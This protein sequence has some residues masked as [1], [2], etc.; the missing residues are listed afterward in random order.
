MTVST[1]RVLDPTTLT[2]LAEGFAGRIITP[3][4]DGYD[5]A[6]RV[7]NASIDKRPA[8]IV[9]PTGV[10]DVMA[11]LRF[12]REHDL[13]VAVRG[14]GHS[15]A[16]H[17]TCDGG[18]VIDLGA[19]KGIR[20]D[21]RGRRARV[22]PGV[23]WSE[24]DR[25][26]QTFGLATTGG[27][28]GSTGVAGFTLG[29]GLGWLQRRYG[30]ACDNLVSADVVLA[31][32]SMVRASADEDPD[33]LWALRGGGGNF[34]IVTSF[35]LELH[36]VGPQVLGG[37]LLFPAER[38]PD[39]IAAYRDLRDDTPDELMLGLVLRLAPPA[40]FLPE[41]V[42]GRPVVGI[43]A[44]HC[45]A[46]ED[47]ER[48]I[49]PIRSV[50][51]PIVDLVEPR[52]YVQMQTM[53]D[54]S[55]GPGFRNYWKAEFLS[56]LPDAATDVLLEHLHSITSPLSDFKFA[57]LGGAV[58][59]ATEEATA[60]GHRDAFTILNVNARWTDPGEDE[61]HVA[62]TRS[63]WRAMQPFS[64]GGTYTNFTSED[65][66]DR[67]VGSFGP[68]KYARLAELKRRYDPTNLFRLNQNIVPAGGPTTD[69]GA[70]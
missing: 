33:L 47:G 2:R 68:S 52:P 34:G 4:D 14:G 10:A 53:Q 24:L 60:F 6:R 58:G 64:A 16:G 59:R 41:E 40:P 31:D 11:A 19:M 13:V 22:Q 7:W 56:G 29:G 37:M 54:P 30:L 43:A 12:A 3:G 45:G 15:V 17:S 39:L 46:L 25:E 18:I 57:Y 36:P 44:I 9:R 49:R 42:H 61:R 21:P 65:D 55:W 48:A 67:V 63:L 32:G 66:A 69:G 70:T 5:E 1:D 8:A 23:V 20:V 28:V 38:A 62:W 35:E 27:L 50:A 26:T 51:E